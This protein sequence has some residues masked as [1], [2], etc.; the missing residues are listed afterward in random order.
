ML[1]QQQNP[2]KQRELYIG[3]V[4]TGSVNEPM[5]KELFTQILNQCEGFRPEGG[6]AVLNVQVRVGNSSSGSGQGTTY[7]FVEFRDERSMGWSCT[8]AT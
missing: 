6:P 8:G 4:P 1:P 5:M 3:N 2:K 7:A